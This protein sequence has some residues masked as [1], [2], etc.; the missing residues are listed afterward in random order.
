MIFVYVEDTRSGAHSYGYWA[1]FVK[2]VDQER[3]KIR[4]QSVHLAQYEEFTIMNM[5]V[6][7]ECQVEL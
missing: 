7:H 6:H 4:A 3:C 5:F 2:D 1:H